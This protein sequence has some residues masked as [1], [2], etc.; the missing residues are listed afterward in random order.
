MK[1]D[2]EADAATQQALADFRKKHALAAGGP[3]DARLV[4][5]LNAAAGAAA[6]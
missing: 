2:G 4:K 1:V 6:R 5:T 3:I